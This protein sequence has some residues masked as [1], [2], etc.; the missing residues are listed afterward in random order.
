MRTGELRVESGA[1][2]EGSEGHGGR[3][4]VSASELRR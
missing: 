4:G 1:G 3:Q 2:E